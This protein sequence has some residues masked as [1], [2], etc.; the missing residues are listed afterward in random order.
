MATFIP[1]QSISTQA[2]TVEVT[3]TPTA[4][5]PPGRHRFQLIVVDDSGNQSVPTV[6]EIIVID[7]QRPTA[8]LDAPRTVPLGSSFTLSGTRSFDLPPGKIVTYNWVRLP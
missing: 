8:V 5:L 4:P 3:V 2:P 1:G 7:D 6:A